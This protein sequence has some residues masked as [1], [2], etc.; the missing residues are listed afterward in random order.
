VTAEHRVRITFKLFATLSE[1]LPRELDGHRSADHEIA[2]DVPDGTALQAVLDRFPMPRALIHLV[3]VNGTY[4]PPER[5]SGHP[6]R[7]GD[8]VA[9]WPPV[10]GG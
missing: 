7:E 3:L 2:V 10:A 9:V 4:V 1:Y 8:A 6:L 5:R